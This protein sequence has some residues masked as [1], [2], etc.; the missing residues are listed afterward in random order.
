VVTVV[1]VVVV[2]VMVT[3]VMMTVMTVVVMVTVV[4]AVAAAVHHMPTAAAVTTAAV[5]TAVTTTM[6]AT[7]TASFST[8][9]ES[10]QADNDRCG[11]GEDCKALEHDEVPLV[12][13]EE[14]GSSTHG[15][16]RSSVWFIASTLRHMPAGAT[17]DATEA[18]AQLIDPG[19]AARA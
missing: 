8:G 9:G 15:S 10:C 2:V 19:R 3:V 14:C 17:S 6:T 11:K 5:A 1:V 4:T 16:K 12:P 7:V 13:R 18:A